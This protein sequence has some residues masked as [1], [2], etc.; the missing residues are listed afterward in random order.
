MLVLVHEWGHYITAVKY[1]VKVME[2][3][4]GFPPKAKVLGKK[5]DTEFTLNWIP[6]GGFVRIFGEDPNDK[7]EEGEDKKRAFYNQSHRRQIIVLS[8][9][10]ACNFILA[11]LFFTGAFSIG[12]PVVKENLPP[13]YSAQSSLTVTSVDSEKSADVAGVLAGDSIVSIFNEKDAVFVA[14]P[15]TEEFLKVIKNS[16]NEEVSLVLERKGKE[17]E[18][19]VTPKVDEEGEVRIGVSL[20]ELSTLKLPI[21][22]AFIYSVSSSIRITGD[23]TLAIFNLIADA[24]TG[25][26][27]LEGLSGPVGIANATGEASSL[28]FSYLLILAAILSLN[29]AVINLLPFPALDG[30]RIVIAIFEGVS[31]KK[32]HPKIVQTANTIGFLLLIGLMLI[33]TWNDVRNLF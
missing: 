18:L 22:K 27:S 2:F 26:G 4:F 12:V 33:I 13:G 9:G 19:P 5:G 17:V 24:V 21:H 28:G 29:L 11:I 3:G 10:V 6:F 1:G 8:A 15:N 7:L 16:E 14:N 30:G 20:E 32:A 31:K 23:I 25:K